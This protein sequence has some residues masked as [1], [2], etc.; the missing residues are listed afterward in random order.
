MMAIA[1][2]FL[3]PMSA[4][5]LHVIVSEFVNR[6]KVYIRLNI[7]EVRVMLDPEIWETVGK[8]FPAEQHDFDI[9]DYFYNVCFDYDLDNGTI[10][11]FHNKLPASSEWHER[12]PLHLRFRSDLSDMVCLT[13]N[14]SGWFDPHE[15]PINKMIKY[16]KVD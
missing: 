8:L 7:L 2:K 3:Q 14:G 11:I 4:K 10:F 5:Y 15:I 6:G 16:Y 12:I 1:A 9:L 13:N